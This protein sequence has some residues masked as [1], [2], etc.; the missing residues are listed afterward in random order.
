MAGRLAVQEG[1]KY[2]EKTFG[3]AGVLLGGVPG[4]Y[5]VEVVYAG[6]DHYYDPT[7]ELRPPADAQ[8]R[9]S[10]HRPDLPASVDGIVARCLDAEPANICR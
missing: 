5:A 7:S 8:D 10:Q 3:G 4:V 2:L 6:F 9:L 1:A